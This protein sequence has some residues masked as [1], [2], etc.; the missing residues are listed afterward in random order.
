MHGEVDMV[1]NGVEFELG[2]GVNFSLNELADMFGKDYPK[3]YIPARKGE[4]D[5][6]LCTDTKAH[7]VLGWN[8]T[9]NIEDYIRDFVDTQR[10]LNE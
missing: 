9:R 4:Y 8:P 10:F 5:V 6:T 2:R 7:E 1:Y 3:K